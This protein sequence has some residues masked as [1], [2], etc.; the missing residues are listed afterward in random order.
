MKVIFVMGCPGSGKTAF[1]KKYLQEHPQEDCISIDLLDFQCRAESYLDIVDSYMQALG[2]LIHVIALIQ[3][4]GGDGTVIFEHT[5]V[6]ASR[7]P[8]YIEAIKSMCE[9]ED[10]ELIAYYTNPTAVQYTKM[11]YKDMNRDKDDMFDYM[12]RGSQR[13]LQAFDVP[14]EQEGFDKVYPIKCEV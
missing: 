9:R 12:V 8:M 2:A 13:L 3:E 4:T 1:V 11:Y 5:L 7:R 14:T 10:I 6:K